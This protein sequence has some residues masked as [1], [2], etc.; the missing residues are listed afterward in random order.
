M[1]AQLQ[2]HYK[3]LDNIKAKAT[4]CFLSIPKSDLSI[5]HKQYH[6]TTRHSFPL[7]LSHLHKQ[8]VASGLAI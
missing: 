7:S 5:R 4:L 6:Y 8:Q 1:V 3:I 2:Q